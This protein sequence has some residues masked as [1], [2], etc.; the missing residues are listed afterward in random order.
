VRAACSG[1]EAPCLLDTHRKL[2]RD[3]LDDPGH[4]V[5]DDLRHR[6]APQRDHGRAA[7]HGLDHDQAER[8]LPADREQHRAGPRQQ[9][10]L[11]GGVG[12]PEQLD[13]L[14]EPWLDL[15]LE[16]G[17]LHRLA[18]LAGEHDRQ[19]GRPG[20]VDGQVR[21]LVRVHPAE[22]Q[23]EVLLVRLERE[24]AR[25][26]RVVHGRGPGQPRSVRALRLRDGDHPDGLAQRAVVLSLLAVHR[27]V[28]GDDRGDLPAAPEQ[29]A[30]QRVIVDH[31]DVEIVEYLGDQRGVDD[32]RERVPEPQ[33]R[34]LGPQGDEPVGP[35]QVLARPDQCDLVAA[36]R[37]VVD[38]VGDHG[39]HAAVGRR[40][41]LE[42]GWCNHRD[43]EWIGIIRHE[44]C[45]GH[46]FPPLLL[47]RPSAAFSS[48]QPGK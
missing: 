23:D 1:I 2:R 12:D 7:G 16:V 5:D 41:H 19:P 6:A 36:G 48:S 46:G 40:G 14:P 38:Q 15:L 4:A 32:L 28:H 20:C 18:A 44:H 33:A 42:P 35:G 11:G 26:D 39:L 10:A 24:R 31:V 30:G 21:S 22:E 27:A 9:V 13:V 34:R 45:R 17:E 29:R 43:T 25:P 3:V 47:A 8:L 37:E